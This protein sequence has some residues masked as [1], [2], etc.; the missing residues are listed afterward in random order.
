VLV[1]GAAGV[2]VSVSGVPVTVIAFTMAAG[3]ITE[4]DAIADPD[5]FRP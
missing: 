1:N 4:I 5:V 2:I 3:V